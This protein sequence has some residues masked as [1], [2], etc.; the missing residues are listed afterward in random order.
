MTTL[1]SGV[2]GYTI[3][4]TTPEVCPNQVGGAGCRGGPGGACPRDQTMPNQ[5]WWSRSVL[6]KGHRWGPSLWR[7]VMI[8]SA[9][10]VQP[11]M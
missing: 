10:V 8:S 1:P 7:S 5:G 4:L 6:F 11:T 3:N 2:T 9:T